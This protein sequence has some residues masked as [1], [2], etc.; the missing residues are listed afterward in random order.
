M[1]K[2]N[3]SVPFSRVKNSRKIEEASEPNPKRKNKKNMMMMMMMKKKKKKKKKKKIIPE[4]FS[5]TNY[6]HTRGYYASNYDP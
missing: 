2:V 6:K 4:D 3:L 1:F 5:E